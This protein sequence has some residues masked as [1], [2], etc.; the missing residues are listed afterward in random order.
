MIAIMLHAAFN[1]LLQLNQILPV[2]I[3]IIIM[4]LVLQRLLRRRAGKLI[5]VTDPSEQ[6]A[7]TM[8]N[9]D[10]EVV[11]E[12]LGMW[13]NTKRYVDVI[14]ICQRLLQRDPDNKIVQMFKAQAMDKM[15]EGD[16][17][18]KILQNMF[19]EK[20]NSSIDQLTKEKE[21]TDNLS[22]QAPA[23]PAPPAAGQ[24][25]PAP[26]VPPRPPEKEFFDLK[27]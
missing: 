24:V 2:V 15:K 5:M 14:H 19:P 20:G 4:G 8:A 12:L 18:G 10:E 9:K 26:G 17:Y 23:E 11:I 6:R 22:A 13:F 25:Q 27:I 7:S 1:F 3:Y 16:S 21:K